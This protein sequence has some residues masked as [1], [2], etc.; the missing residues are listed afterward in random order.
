MSMFKISYP[1]VYLCV[2]FFRWIA[3]I[4]DI[5]QAF[6]ILLC[7]S[8]LVQDSGCNHLPLPHPASVLVDMPYIFSD[9]TVT[10]VI[11]IP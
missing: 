7:H 4:M 9:S 3:I 1:F 10:C 6:Q 8:A 11:S 2:L 5:L